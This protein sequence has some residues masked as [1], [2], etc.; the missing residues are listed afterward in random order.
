MNKHIAYIYL[1][2]AFCLLMSGCSQQSIV[3]PVDF[4]VVLDSAN[5]Y[6]PDEKIH[7]KFRG[8]ADYIVFYSG[9][10]GHEYRY[11]DRT[12]VPI[13]DVNSVKLNLEI[14]TLWNARKVEALSVYTTDKFDGLNGADGKADRAK[15]KDIFSNGMQGWTDLEYKAASHGVWLKQSYD[16]SGLMSNFSM[17]FHWAPNTFKFTNSQPTFHLNGN[18]EMRFGENGIVKTSLRDLNY[19]TIVMNEQDPPYLV[20]HRGDTTN[21][22]TMHFDN[23]QYAIEFEG[24]S[25]S[26]LTYEIDAWC[27]SK[28]MALNSILPDTGQQIKS[29]MNPILD[30]EYKYTKPGTY[31]AVFVGVNDN[32]QGHKVAAKEVTVIITGNPINNKQ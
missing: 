4:D 32:Y 26:Y 22:G 14:E 3:T 28:P 27:I 29:M 7:F 1:L 24:C 23:T 10:A 21:I 6:R 16:I 9:E 25:Q 30:F 17:A 20:G 13:E 2:P 31:K 8:D 19:Q 5:I 18:I 15:M 12:S 11:K